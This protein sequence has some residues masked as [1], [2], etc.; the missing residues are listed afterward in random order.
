MNNVNLEHGS[1][2]ALAW[3][4]QGLGS[5]SLVFTRAMVSEGAGQGGDCP[6]RRGQHCSGDGLTP[7]RGPGKTLVPLGGAQGRS[8][9]GRDFQMCFKDVKMFARQT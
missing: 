5:D 2:R 8:Q 3:H 9:G 1:E 4:V 6:V 7:E